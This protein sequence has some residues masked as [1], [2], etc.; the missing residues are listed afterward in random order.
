MNPCTPQPGAFLELAQQLLPADSVLLDEASRTFYSG[1]FSEERGPVA[2]A[3]LRPRSARDISEL[4][5]A[6]SRCGIS[7]AARGGGMSYTKAHVPGD[8]LTAIL[9]LGGLDKI[10][11]IDTQDRY[12]IVE[13]GVTWQQLRDALRPT[14]YRV[15]YLGTLSGMVATV[16]G[17]ASQN[18]T[19]MG[20]MTLAEHVIGLE[21]VLGNGDIIHTGSSITRNTLP[22]YRYNGPDFTGMFLCDSGALG[23][24]T[25]IVLHLEP[26]PCASYGC[27]AFA[28]RMSLVRAQREMALGNLHTEA[29][30]FDEYF[31]EEYARHPSPGR[32]ETRR[33]LASYW[34]AR[35]N[36]SL[37]G[38]VN[39]A[40]AWHPR[41]LRFLAG[42]GTVMYYIAEGHD[43]ASADRARKRIDGIVRRNGGRLIPSSIPFA[44]R[45]GPF[46]NIGDM[47]TNAQGE[48]NYPVNAKFAAGQAELAMSTYLDFLKANQAEMDRFGVRMACNTLLHG[49]FFGIEPVVFWKR[50]LSPYRSHFASEKAKAASAR[51]DEDPARTDYATSLRYE[52]ARRFREIGALHVQWGRVYNYADALS[53]PQ[54][55]SFV[56]GIKALVD[57]GR[58]INPGSLGL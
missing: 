42:R 14:G 44:L 34:S 27:V 11:R 31:V 8:G 40:R 48:V 39:L 41:G 26:T 57:P 35:G 15:P 21:V 12:A 24:K 37:R 51:T 55:R 33:M 20:R 13:P 46:L 58:V 22:F 49:H 7:I 47:M 4:V 23:I 43:Q 36:R 45:H 29:F 5:Q 25:R 54:T 19:G 1:D 17:G 6:A 10:I 50:P 2:I 56:A 30:A 52:L 28:D 9:D 53:S 16:G 3:V 32:E 38:V 18:A